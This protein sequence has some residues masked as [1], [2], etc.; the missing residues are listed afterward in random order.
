MPS[1][2][3]CYISVDSVDEIAKK[4]KELGG[5]IVMEPMD[6]LESGRMVGVQDPTG[7]MINFWEP[8]NHIGAQVVNK[9]G[10]MCWNELN[11]R[12]VEGAKKF[13]GELLGW[14]FETDDTGYT[15]IK[16]G[17]RWN[18][19]IFELTPEMGD[20]L[21]YWCVYFTV[22]DIEAA[23]EK[24]G[25]LGGQIHMPTKEIGPGKIAMIACPAGTTCM[26]MQMNDEPDEWVE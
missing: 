4:V 3:S 23:V 15:S 1:Y 16:N 22:E 8:K 2:W 14:E 10:A 26:I 20:F 19:G 17:D 12:D 7:A 5:V 9:A 25:S 24:V 18:G 21:P 6:V 11:T 13:Y